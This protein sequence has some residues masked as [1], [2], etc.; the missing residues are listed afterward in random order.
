MGRK[1][2]RKVNR[3]VTEEWVWRIRTDKE[4]REL[5]K[6]LIWYHILKGEDWSGWDMYSKWIQQ[7]W[8][9]NISKNYA[10]K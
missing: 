6:L 5:S 4:L 1:I 8:L 3:P 2:L 10:I 7:W 9:K